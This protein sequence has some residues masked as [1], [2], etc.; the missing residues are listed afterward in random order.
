MFPL[1]FLHTLSSHPSS[2]SMISMDRAI[3]TLPPQQIL[4]LYRLLQQLPHPLP[5]PWA[6]QAIIHSLNVT[7]DRSLLSFLCHLF[8]LL[9]IA[10]CIPS[11]VPPDINSPPNHQDVVERTP[12][13]KKKTWQG[14]TSCWFIFFK[15]IRPNHSRHSVQMP[16][17]QIVATNQFVFVFSNLP[18]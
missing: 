1:S 5:P 4:C 14:L 15:R 6:H 7:Q 17:Y 2:V 16:H 9:Q 13:T 10:I 3:T 12:E 18:F 8:S 11:E